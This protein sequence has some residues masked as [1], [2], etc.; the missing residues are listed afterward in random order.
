[1]GTVLLSA[2]I[3]VIPAIDLTQQDY[4]LAAIFGGVIG[5]AGVGMILLARSTTG[6]TELLAVLIQHFIRH[7][8]VVQIMQVIDEMIMH[9][10]I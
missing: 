7:Y 10:G 2:W 3:Y 6:G 8:S 5:V 9:T 4:L 1:M